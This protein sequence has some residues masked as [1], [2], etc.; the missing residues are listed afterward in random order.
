MLDILFGLLLLACLVYHKK[1][2]SIYR[3]SK[4]LV[5]RLIR[6][7]EVIEAIDDF[8]PKNKFKMQE[9]ALSELHIDPTTSLAWIE[10]LHEGKKFRTYFPYSYFA[11]QNG[12]KVKLK[13]EEETIDITHAPGIA[14]G[15]SAEDFGAELILLENKDGEVELRLTG[16]ERLMFYDNQE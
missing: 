11:V 10:F 6:F 5:N 7:S 9:E 1:L 8:L 13:F 15:F 16:K 3:Q 4:V 12:T 2:Y 14:Y